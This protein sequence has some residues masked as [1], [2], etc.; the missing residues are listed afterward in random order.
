MT[1]NVNYIIRSFD[2]NF[3]Q[4][5]V[6]VE[7]FDSPFAIDLPIDDDGNL[8]TGSV[9]DSYIRGFIPMFILERKAKIAEGITNATDI[10]SLVV[11]PPLPEP[12]VITFEQKKLKKKMDVEALL[13]QKTY[14]GYRHD[15][16]EPHGTLTLQ[17]READKTNWLAVAQ[18]ASIMISQGH[19]NTSIG[20]VRTAENINVTMTASDALNTMLSMQGQQKGLLEYSWYLKDEIINSTTESQLNNINIEAN[21]PS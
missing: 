18:V 1:V 7:G 12:P 13:D 5:E 2:E 4:I 16:G 8:P 14:A 17:T 11:T 3:A 21:W 6:E 10:S 15:F 9:L 20:S 19:G